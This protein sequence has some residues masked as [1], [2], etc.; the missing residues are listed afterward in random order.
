[1]QEMTNLSEKEQMSLL[2]QVEEM[3]RVFW[4]PDLQQCR[5]LVSGAFLGSFSAIETVYSDAAE[6]KKIHRFVETFEN[7]QRLY[8]FLSEAFIRLFVSTRGQITPLYQS[9]YENEDRLMMGKS[10]VEMKKRLAAVKLTVHGLL[11]EPPDHIS[12]ELEYLYFLLNTGWTG[13]DNRYLQ[14]AG[15]FASEVMLP[16][17]NKLSDKLQSEKACVFYPLAAAM[18]VRMLQRISAFRE[19]RSPNAD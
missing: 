6:I 8:D 9:C 18:L 3:C 7:E 5:E 10:A 14:Q 2:L 12:V 19:L 17:V 16:W 11:N 1:M 13:G 4:G 15:D